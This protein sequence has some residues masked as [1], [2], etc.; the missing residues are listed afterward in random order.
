[1]AW[2]NT[3]VSSSFPLPAALAVPTEAGKSPQGAGTQT[4]SD[5]STTGTLGSPEWPELSVEVR[6]H[7]PHQPGA[8]S[9]PSSSL[10]CGMLEWDAWI[11]QVRLGVGRGCSK[12][13]AAGRGERLPEG[14]ASISPLLKSPSTCLTPGPCWELGLGPLGAPSALQHLHPVLRPFPGGPQGLAQDL[15]QSRARA[16][17]NCTRLRDGAGT[18]W[19]TLGLGDSVTGQFAQHSLENPFPVF[20][21]AGEGFRVHTVSCWINNSQREAGHGDLHPSHISKDLGAA[22]GMTSRDRMMGTVT[23]ELWTPGHC[24]LSCQ[25]HGMQGDAPGEHVWIPVPGTGLVS[26]QLFL[27]WRMWVDLLPVEV[28]H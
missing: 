6:W 1:M 9:C 28:R 3:K 4:R 26:K 5:R 24:C 13:L 21:P 8:L 10:L 2:E 25:G 19:T 14:A 18:G 22:A 12:G 7:K 20:L 15:P 23:I 27:P 17:L 16:A 11:V